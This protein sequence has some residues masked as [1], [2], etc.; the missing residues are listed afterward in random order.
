MNQLRDCRAKGTDPRRWWIPE[1]LAAACRKVSRHARV[2]WRK[3]GVVVRRDC[4]GAKVEQ[5]IW[6]VRMHHEGR[7]GTKDL[8][9]KR[10]LYLRKKRV[11]AIVIRGWSSGQLSSLGRGPTYKN[12]KK[13]LEL[14][15]MMKR[16]NG[17]SSGLRRMRDQTVEGRPPPKWKKKLQREREGAGGGGGMLPI[18]MSISIFSSNS[19]FCFTP[20]IGPFHFLPMEY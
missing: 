20:K 7:R 18:L 19:D 4:I 11:T 8:G 10:L 17:M 2:A 5:R 13:I 14:E 3:R 1:K 12:V 6:R 9:S 15:F 16:A